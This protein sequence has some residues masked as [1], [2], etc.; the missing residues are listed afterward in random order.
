MKFANLSHGVAVISVTLLVTIFGSLVE[1]SD[2]P[3][4]EYTV[5]INDIPFRNDIAETLVLLVT[6]GGIGS[7]KAY[8]NIQST[9]ILLSHV[10]ENMKVTIKGDDLF[11]AVSDLYRNLFEKENADYKHYKMRDMSCI[12]GNVELDKKLTK[13]CIDDGRVSYFEK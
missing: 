12:S 7:I 10:T 4:K 2:C 3:V 8:D 9:G 5:R 13:I 11:P 6:N 1:S